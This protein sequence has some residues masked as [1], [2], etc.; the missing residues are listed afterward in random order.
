M[1]NPTV[2][3]RVSTDLLKND[4]AKEVQALSS[5]EKTKIHKCNIKKYKSSRSKNRFN[6]RTKHP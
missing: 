4:S 3:K 6:S 2:Y 5:E 1:S